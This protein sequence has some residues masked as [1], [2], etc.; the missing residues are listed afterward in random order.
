MSGM[1]PDCLIGHG[2]LM[3]RRGA[4]TA[5][6]HSA[7]IVPREGPRKGL[8]GPRTLA[9]PPILPILIP[10]ER[11]SSGCSLV[12]WDFLS[13]PQDELW[14]CW[15]GCQCN[16][17]RHPCF[18]NA[19]CFTRINFRFESSPPACRDHSRT[20]KPAYDEPCYTGCYKPQGEQIWIRAV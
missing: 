16:L 15:P 17:F 8:I 19:T 9:H 11:A 18:V 6:S 5:S 14:F 1:P 7:S 3:Y 20:I 2:R 10:L 13:P 4:S 12:S